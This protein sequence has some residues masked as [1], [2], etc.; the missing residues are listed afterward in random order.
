[1]RV[2]C[3][4]VLLAYASGCV[5]DY[6]DDKDFFLLPGPGIVL[7]GLVYG[8]E[9]PG[10]VLQSGIHFQSLSKSGSFKFQDR[11]EPG[12]AYDVVLAA[13]PS[14]YICNIQNGGG[15]LTEDRLNVR[16]DCL[17]AAEIT[18]ADQSVIQGSQPI[19]VRFTRSMTGC[20]VASSGLGSDAHTTAWSSTNTANDTLTI[21]P[22][23]NWNAGANRIL[24]LMNCNDSDGYFVLSTGMRYFVASDVRYVSTAGNDMGGTNNCSLSAS[25]CATIG[26]AVTQATGCGGANTCAIQI[27]DGTYNLGANAFNMQPL[28]SL[29]GG[30]SA[31]FS[32]RNPWANGTVLTGGGNGCGG[33]NCTIRFIAALDGNTAID[34]LEIL[35]PGGTDSTAV[36]MMGGGSFHN[37]RLSPGTGTN[38]RTGIIVSSSPAR[39]TDLEGVRILAQDGSAQDGIGVRMDSGTLR[40]HASVI[41]GSAATQRSIGLEING[42]NGQIDSSFIFARDAGNVSHGLAINSA[43]TWRIGHNYIRSQSTAATESIGMEIGANPSGPIYNNL[44][45]AGGGTNQYCIR[46]L[47]GLPAAVT[48]ANNNL[49]NCPG[50]FLRTSVQSYPS[51]CS[52]NFATNSGCGTLYSGA[53]ASGNVNF[54]PSFVNGSSDFRFSVSNP[55]SVSQGGIDPT[56]LSQPVLP[57]AL[58]RA[59]PGDAYFSIGPIEAH[60]GCTP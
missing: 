34:G 3:F 5:K 49:W 18:P 23:G 31:D 52:G 53:S 32:T 55:C 33:Q 58:S 24:Q 39:T 19:Q 15:V 8:L 17:K 44:I 37:V 48:M 20:T 45:Q 56:T 13:V 30:Y 59:R 46:D 54:T 28:I 36:F 11:F 57:D 51:I 7:G 25:P 41:Q 60:L 43:G 22:A 29:M 1:M 14:G 12:E 10:L 6:P 9:D 26:H 42:G 50:A 2:G 35:G 38:S 21:T 16:V 4:L 40:T 27:A 47:A